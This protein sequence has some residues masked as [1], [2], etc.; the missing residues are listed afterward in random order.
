LKRIEEG[1]K[2]RFDNGTF[3]G[4]ID[5][6]PHKYCERFDPLFKSCIQ[7]DREERCWCFAGN[8]FCDYF[9][10]GNYKSIAGQNRTI[11]HKK[12]VNFFESAPEH[13]YKE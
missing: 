12:V 1:E 11:N 9:I 13:A 4:P 7:K 6:S 3:L 10:F 5:I 8:Y 2:E